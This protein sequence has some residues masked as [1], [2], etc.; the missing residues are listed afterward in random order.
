M[1]NEQ[2]PLVAPT[3]GGYED[4][5]NKK[6][7]TK[8]YLAYGFIATALC[9]GFVAT[10]NGTF[11]PPEANLLRSSTSDVII[12]VSDNIFTPDVIGW[13]GRLGQF[14]KAAADPNKWAGV[15]LY[16]FQESKKGHY[17][18]VVP[19]MVNALPGGS[20]SWDSVCIDDIPNGGAPRGDTDASAAWR[21]DT[22]TTVHKAGVGVIKDQYDVRTVVGACLE[23][24]QSGKRMF[25]A[26]FHGSIPIV[27][28]HTEDE[29]K[30]FRFM[31]E[32]TAQCGNNG[33]L[34]GDFNALQPQTGSSNDWKK[35][36]TKNLGSFNGIDYTFTLGEITVESAEFKESQGYTG[37]DHKPLELKFDFSGGSAPTPSSSCT[38]KGGDMFWHPGQPAGKLAC[39]V[40][41]HE[42]NENGPLRCR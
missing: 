7:E 12:A 21:R 38:P 9:M 10:S 19:T 34:M 17:T 22:W 26:S 3:A 11:T 40:G 33:M 42:V 6:K 27:R 35:A 1:P 5:R 15:T 32:Q 8:G 30:V 14:T 2:V 39:C 25:F 16:A 28:T 18:S 24:K 36:A 37:S 31:D 23:N 41:L 29:A 20:G 4:E 13:D